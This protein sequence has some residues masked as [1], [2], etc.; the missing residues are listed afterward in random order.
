MKYRI[1]EKKC[2]LSGNPFYQAQ[3]KLFNLFW[4]NCVDLLLYR[5]ENGDLIRED[6][7]GFPGKTISFDYSEVEDYINFKLKLRKLNRWRFM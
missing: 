4:V 2:I 6:I 3:E 5:S 7:K 1:L